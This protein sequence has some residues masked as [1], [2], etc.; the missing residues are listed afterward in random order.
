MQVNVNMTIEEMM[1]ME[2]NIREAYYGGFDI[3]LSDD[4]FTFEKRTKRPPR[5]NLNTLISFGN[6]VC[7]RLYSAKFITRILTHGLDFCIH[8]TIEDS[9]S[10]LIWLRFSNQYLSTGL[11]LPLLEKGLYLLSILIK[12]PGGSF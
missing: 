4:D 12:N 1:A 6:S 9:R 7:I 3:I 8:Q 11:F 5:N 2:G 10:I